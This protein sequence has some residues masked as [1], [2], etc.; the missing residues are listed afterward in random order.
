MTI[1][2]LTDL[3]GLKEKNISELEKIGITSISELAKAI[4]SEE[5]A[6]NVIKTLSGIG[7]KTVN[8]WK[9]ML[10]D[11]TTVD[12]ASSE[13]S[14]AK[15]DDISNKQYKVKPKPKLDDITKNMLIKRLSI[16]KRRP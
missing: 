7:P 16:S 3:R 1:K 13:N 8:E 14:K 12:M 10:V 11:S 6:K 15:N 4:N 2:A 9:A 5:G